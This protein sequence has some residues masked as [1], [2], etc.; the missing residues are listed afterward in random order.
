MVG[1]L[2]FAAEAR[3]TS[4]RRLVCTIRLWR[5][6]KE[7]TGVW[8]LQAAEGSLLWLFAGRGGVGSSRVSWALMAEGPRWLWTAGL[9]LRCYRGPSVAREL[10]VKM[11]HKQCLFSKW[12]LSA[13]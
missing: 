2:L 13:R 4:Q 1:R 8:A 5:G 12:R 9:G 11:E 6:R 10:D 7:D 3:T